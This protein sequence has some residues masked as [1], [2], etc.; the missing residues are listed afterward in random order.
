ML[1]VKLITVLALFQ[2]VFAHFNLIYPPARG[3][4]ESKVHIFPCG[5]FDEPG[6]RTEVPINSSFL[7]VNST[8]NANYTYT[9]NVLVDPHPILSDF[10]STKIIYI[11]DGNI[12]HPYEACLHVS[13][14][15]EPKAIN[16]ARATIQVIY[17]SNGTDFYQV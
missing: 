3:L 8:E 4:D 13:Y 7:E 12:S 11:A 17:H 14:K 1:F 5:G 15:N 10:N 6:Y 16:A 2:T 9:V